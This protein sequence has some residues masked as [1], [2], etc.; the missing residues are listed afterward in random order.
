MLG[1]LARV[2]VAASLIGLVAP[3][4]ALANTQPAPIPLDDYVVSANFSFQSGGT[5]WSGIAQIEDERI[6]GVR[7]ASFFFDG[8]GSS[9]SCDAG[10]PSD[11]SDD[12][13]GT[14]LIE[15]FSTSTSI[16]SL[17]LAN[18]LSSGGFDVALTGR[19]VTTDA[20][21]GEIIRSRA[22][23]HR[24]KIDLAGVT[25]P[26]SQTATYLVTTPEGT[27]RVTKTVTLVG[28]TGTA[29]IDNQPATVDYAVFQHL[30]QT[31]APA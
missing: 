1:R 18:D 20:C 24:F 2:L 16:K 19:E 31:V 8:S 13:V 15:F 22:D 7:S 14:Q 17:T 25:F 27:F 12:Y 5:T 10:T 28:A 26:V 6:S 11:P 4:S 3:L 23:K 9:K 30:V 29:T 21:T